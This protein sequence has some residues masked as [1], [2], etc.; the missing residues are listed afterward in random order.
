MIRAFNED[1]PYPQFI[2]EQLAGDAVTEDAATGFLVASAVLLPGQIGKDE[3]SVRLARQDSLD[4]IIVATG[5]TFLGLSIGCARCHDHKFDPI[6]ARDYYTMQAFFA[7][8]EY[9]ERPLR[10][11]EAWMPGPKPT[12]A[13]IAE[14]RARI[15]RA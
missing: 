14:V 9:G 13:R 3:E 5:D 1:R 6:S 15:D 2:L 8:V 12:S 7:G 10:N 4:E 11:P